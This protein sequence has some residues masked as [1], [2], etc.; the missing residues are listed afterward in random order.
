[1]VLFCRTRQPEREL[2]SPFDSSEEPCECAFYEKS[3]G[4]CLRAGHT[5]RYTS[6]DS[7]LP[8]TDTETGP[9]T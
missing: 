5:T 2:G 4:T 7:R 6:R 1:M 9:E 3:V 8:L